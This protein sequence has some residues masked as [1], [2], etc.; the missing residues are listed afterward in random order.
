MVIFFK[1]FPFT[2]VGLTSTYT[3]NALRFSRI[4]HCSYML[5][6][7]SIQICP[8]YNIYKF[9][10]KKMILTWNY[11]ALLLHIPQHLKPLVGMND[12]MCFC[13]HIWSI[14]GNKGYIPIQYCML[15]HRRRLKKILGLLLCLGLLCYSCFAM[16]ESVTPLSRNHFD[17]SMIKIII[18][19]LDANALN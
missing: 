1:K 3:D 17:S 13:L 15:V 2:F 16:K 11:F 7:T 19:V 6:V 5:G 10:M 18:N 14:T 9:S 8:C 4:L 12:F